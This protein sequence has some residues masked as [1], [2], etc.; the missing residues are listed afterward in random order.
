MTRLHQEV[1]CSEG[2]LQ[3]DIGFIAANETHAVFSIRIPRAWLA[4]NHFFLNVLSA[5]PAAM[6]G[7]NCRHASRPLEANGNDCWR[8]SGA[9][10][11][12]T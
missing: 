7:C 6:A 12:R 8:V 11:D 5:L 2:L 3:T 10:N 9:A 1:E 4:E